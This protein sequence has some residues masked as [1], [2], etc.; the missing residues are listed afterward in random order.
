MPDITENTQAHINSL[1]KLRLVIKIQ[2]DLDFRI[3][4]CAEN[5]SR[6]EVLSGS[7]KAPLEVSVVLVASITSKPL[8]W[9]RN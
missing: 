2:F 6:G 7:L 1:K 3:S 9:I 8:Q 5:F 4:T